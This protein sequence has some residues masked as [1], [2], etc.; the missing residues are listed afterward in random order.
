M[1]TD[2]KV[3][4]L[5]AFVVILVGGL[6]YEFANGKKQEPVELA[7][8]SPAVGD[9]HPADSAQRQTARRPAREPGPATTRRA[10]MRTRSTPAAVGKDAVRP[11]TKRPAR[12]DRTSTTRA[13]KKKTAPAPLP[14]KPEPAESRNRG[15]AARKPVPSVKS[16]EGPQEK[17]VSK[18]SRPRGK[19]AVSSPPKDRRSPA[20]SPP[21]KTAAAANDRHRVQAGDTLASLALMY[22]GSERY[23]DLLTE[24]NPQIK[25]PRRLPVG[26][27]VEIPPVVDSAVPGGGSKSSVAVVPARSAR[28]RAASAKEPLTKAKRTYLVKPGDTFYGI[29]AAYL[30]SGPRWRE[31]FELNKSVVRN[32]PKG[33]RPG[34]TLILPDRK[35]SD[36]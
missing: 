4:V 35:E 22:Y 31:I 23:A 30:G 3:G 12:G 2:V 5:C 1:R 7:S 36:G 24:A 21:A 20:E 27:V 13:P 18:D 34:Q 33:L 19:P 9:D 15:R 26:E 14:V 6:Y 32:D 10:P 16:N 11:S 17:L 8:A 29:A 28:S 25:D